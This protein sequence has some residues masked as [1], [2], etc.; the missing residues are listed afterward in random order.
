RYLKI[1]KLLIQK[2]VFELRLLNSSKEWQFLSYSLFISGGMV[3][4][5]NFYALFFASLIEIVLL[6]K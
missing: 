1:K 4:D 3:S 2:P 5:M 6:R